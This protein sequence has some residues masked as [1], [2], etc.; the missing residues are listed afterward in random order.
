MSVAVRGLAERCFC[1]DRRPS[2][3]YF[4][5]SL[6][7]CM[8][9]FFLLLSFS[10]RF[11]PGG[12]PLTFGHHFILKFNLLNLPSPNHWCLNWSLVVWQDRGW[13]GWDI[14]LR[15]STDSFG[16]TKSSCNAWNH[17]QCIRRL[18]SVAKI[19]HS[20][21]LIASQFQ[22]VSVKTHLSLLKETEALEEME[23]PSSLS[24][25]KKPWMSNTCWQL[26]YKSFLYSFQ[27]P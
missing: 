17:D 3:Q 7:D 1:L 18:L 20:Y 22:Q 8:F 16:M 24:S 12:L 11:L 9:C 13:L 21:L 23:I 2:G 19:F 26:N 15:F 4:L 5:C 6:M 25:L 27:S 10:K 14:P